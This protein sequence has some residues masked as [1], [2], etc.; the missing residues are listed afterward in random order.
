MSWDP[1]LPDGVSNVTKT[2]EG[3]MAA[4]SIPPDENGYVGR[5]CTACQ[6]MFRMLSDELA[7][8]PEA[9]SL[10]C[11]YC[12]RQ[13]HSDEFRTEAQENRA[14][15]AAE[16]IAMQQVEDQLDDMMRNFGSKSRS[17][18]TSGFRVEFNYKPASRQPA[19]PLPEI[20][21]ERARRTLTCS[22]CGTHY[23]VYGASAFCPVCGPRAAT[24]TVLEGIARARYMLAL[25]DQLP[26]EERDAAR[27]MGV[28]DGAAADTVK[29]IVTQFEVFT[30][31]QFNARAPN[32]AA[33]VKGKGNVFQRL[34]DTAQL[35]TDHCG[36]DLVAAVGVGVWQRLREDFARRHVLTHSD[37]LVDAKFLTVVATTSL[38]IGQRLVINRQDAEGALDDVETVVRS[39][40]ALP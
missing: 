4:V 32:P 19:R 24:D 22:N 9:A 11:P 14:I 20:V 37:G 10:T 25:E 29:N 8:V 33:S 16:A 17:R 31:D 36:I 1:R 26:P 28:F 38:Q 6:S 3:F 18:S 23:A 2:A 7:G 12:G 13:A 30:R 21:E 34:D 39:I 40:A 27:D 5:R 15:A 35:F